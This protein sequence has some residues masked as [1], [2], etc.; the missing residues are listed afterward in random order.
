MGTAEGDLEVWFS[1]S[2]SSLETSTSTYAALTVTA[3]MIVTVNIEAIL[4]KLGP[5]GFTSLEDFPEFLGRG[6]V[7]REAKADANDSDVIAAVHLGHA[8]TEGRC[9]E[10]SKAFPWSLGVGMT[11]SKVRMKR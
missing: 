9:V 6:S 8:G 1:T 7:A 2:H 11:G 4:G 5:L 3:G 10:L